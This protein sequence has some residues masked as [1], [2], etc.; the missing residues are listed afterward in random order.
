MEN[1]S[2]D[3]IKTDVITNKIMTLDEEIKITQCVYDKAIAQKEEQIKSLTK[4]IT[5]TNKN[6]EKALI[7][8]E[9]TYKLQQENNAWHK[10]II[11]KIHRHEQNIERIDNDMDALNKKQNRLHDLLLNYTSNQ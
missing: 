11:E 1:L 8:L 9:N 10:I 5:E 6:L 4:D 2:V 3:E 7:F